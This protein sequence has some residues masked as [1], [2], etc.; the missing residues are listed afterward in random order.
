MDN[1][2][3]VIVSAGMVTSVGFNAVQ[4]AANVRARVSRYGDISF[5]NIYGKPYI[6]ASIS[7]EALS[8]LPEAIAGRDYFS[9]RQGLLLRFADVALKDCLAAAGGHAGKPPLF[10][11]IPEH[12]NTLPTS[13]ASL[14]DDLAAL[15]PD[16]FDRTMSQALWK[17][18]AGGLQALGEAIRTVQSG[19]ACFA[20][21]GASDTYIDPMILPTLDLKE[22]CKSDRHPDSFVPGEGAGFVM[23]ATREAAQKAGLEAIA[24]VGPVSAGN[25]PGHWE[26]KEP[27]LG[28]GLSSTV[29]ALLAA[30]PAPSPFKEVY[31]TMNGESYWAKEWGVTRI[32]NATAFVDGDR[33]N[34]P[35][36]FFGDVGAASGPILVALAA[37]GQRQGYMES[38]ALVYAS[39]DFGGRA[40]T[41]VA[42]AN[43]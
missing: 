34:H 42:S 27:Y 43:S 31:S 28:E 5:R 20:L 6:V 3:I 23:I 36:E 30:A 32:R 10:Y 21:A 35:A 41:W 22:R 24:C 37:I 12:E 38:P 8:V 13:G 40:A 2:D 26:S 33:M 25:E 15:H 7:R 9:R 16:T 29:Q 19:K 17:G 4:T 39:S 18:R 14:L 1:K 11:A